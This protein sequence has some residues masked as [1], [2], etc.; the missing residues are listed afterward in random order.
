MSEITLPNTTKLEEN[1]TPLIEQAGRAVIDSED[2]EDKGGDLLKMIKGMIKKVEEDR[3]TITGPINTSLTLINKKYK[4][5]AAPLVKA[6][7]VLSSSLVTYKLEQ[8]AIR[9]AE[10]KAEREAMEAKALEQ[11]ALLEEQGKAE[12]AEELV[13]AAM[14]VGEQSQTAAKKS[15]VRSSYGATTSMQDHWSAEVNNILELCAA[16]AAGHVHH[17]A[18]MPN[19]PWLNSAAKTHKDKLNIP[20]VKAVNKPTLRSS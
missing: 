16:V 13:D 11:A 14:T 7:D 12:A 3:V 8:Q 19:Q 20:G 2:S 18:V 15:T 4:A 6:R 1:I 9:E 5:I 17:S 10:E